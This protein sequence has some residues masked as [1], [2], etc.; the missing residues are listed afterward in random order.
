MFPLTRPNQT[1]SRSELTGPSLVVG[2]HQTPV[3]LVAL[4]SAKPLCLAHILV[5][6]GE[7]FAIAR[8]AR[9][10]LAG[11]WRRYCEEK[12]LFKA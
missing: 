10:L 7:R 9:L 12:K 3:G 1:H 8:C 6:T 2:V 11:V 4:E 5:E